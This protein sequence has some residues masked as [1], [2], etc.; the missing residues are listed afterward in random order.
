MSRSTLSASS[1]L[2]QIEGRELGRFGLQIRDIIEEFEDDLE[3]Q[4]R[5]KI[6][7]DAMIEQAKK[8]E[9]RLEEILQKQR[10]LQSEKDRIEILTQKHK[11]EWHIFARLHREKKESKQNKFKMDRRI[12]VAMS[13]HKRL[14]YDSLMS[15]LP[16]Q[17]L[18]NIMK[19]KRK[20]V[21]PGC[22]EL[23]EKTLDKLNVHLRK[24]I[25][26]HLDEESAAKFKERAEMLVLSNA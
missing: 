8:N 16:E 24:I 19:V 1:L 15:L 23:S 3:Y 14:G 13:L 5:Y 21:P 4:R 17:L 26:Y 10:E 25:E 2:R 11:L 22:E 7:Y 20:P 12:A 18:E 6:R 9:Q